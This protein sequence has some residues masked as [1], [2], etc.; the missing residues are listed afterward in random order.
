VQVQLIGM[1]LFSVHIPRFAKQT[2]SV[3]NHSQSFY[4]SC[5]NLVRGLD[6]IQNLPWAVMSYCFVVLMD[7]PDQNLLHG[8]ESV[9]EKLLV[10]QLVNKL[11][12]FR[13]TRSFVTSYPRLLY[14]VSILNHKPVQTL[15]AYSTE[16]YF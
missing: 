8:R 16:I 1:C 7:L 10:T 14:H 12:A 4:F 2:F 9:F 13:V 6:A 11:S 3:Q 5:I 15:S